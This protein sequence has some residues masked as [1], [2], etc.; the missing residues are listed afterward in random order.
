MYFK[1]DGTYR[2][3]PIV[4]SNLPWTEWPIIRYVGGFEYDEERD[5]AMTRAST[6][7]LAYIRDKSKWKSGTAQNLYRR[8][9]MKD[10]E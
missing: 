9:L 3:P 5:A 2:I 8:H 4:H 10:A 6:V 1:E 7:D